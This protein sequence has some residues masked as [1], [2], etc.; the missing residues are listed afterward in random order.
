MNNLGVF[1]KLSATPGPL[2]A[3]QLAEQTGGDALLIGI[4][5]FLFPCP[6]PSREDKQN[7]LIDSSHDASSHGQW[8]GQRSRASD[9]CSE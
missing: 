1:K 6:V 2:T 7:P 9:L 3:A 5:F 8:G 4:T